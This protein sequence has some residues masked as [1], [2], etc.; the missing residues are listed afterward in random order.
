LTIPG[1]NA[2]LQKE[3]IHR[4]IRI[5][6]APYQGPDAAGKGQEAGGILK[7]QYI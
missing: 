4:F 3:G 7:C 6:T 1:A 5:K 2:I